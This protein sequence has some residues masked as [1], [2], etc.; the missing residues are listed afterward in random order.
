M[1]NKKRFVSN[2]QIDNIKPAQD[3]DDDYEEIY[4]GEEECEEDNDDGHAN[5]NK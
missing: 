3:G 2:V 4:E 5:E 1:G